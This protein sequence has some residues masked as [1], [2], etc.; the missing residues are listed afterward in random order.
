MKKQ[1]TMET[2]FAVLLY[3]LFALLSLLLVL[4]GAQVYK[5][6]VENTE[7]RGNVRASLSY[8]ANK[9]R[10]GDESGCVRLES[11][12]GIDVLVL[13]ETVGENVY[14]TL[15]YQ[16]DGALRELFQPVGTVLTPVSGET[17]TAVTQFSMTEKNGLLIIT[18]QNGDEQPQTLHIWRRTA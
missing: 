3:G 4:I 15:I 18:V 5:R 17:L 16:Y 10:A 1:H 7:M 6:I 9:V 14:E 13:E 8:V 11:R 2:L 12:D